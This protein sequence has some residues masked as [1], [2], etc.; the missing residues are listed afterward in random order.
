M[1]VLSVPCSIVVT[2][3]EQSDLFALLRAVFSCVLSRSHMVSLIRCGTSLYRS[4]P[5]SLHCSGM[6]YDGFMINYNPILYN[7]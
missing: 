3:W 6:I 5:S 2:C 4:S 1:F 7:T